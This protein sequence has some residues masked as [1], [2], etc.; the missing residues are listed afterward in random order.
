MSK[1]Y[2]RILKLNAII[3]IM[4]SEFIPVTGAELKRYRASTGTS[5]QEMADLLQVKSPS[6]LS[7]WENGQEI[8][9]P[10]QLLLRMLIHGE[11]PFKGDTIPPNIRDAMWEL[12]MSLETWEEINRRRIAGGYATVTDWIAS[13]V[14]E[15]LHEQL[16]NN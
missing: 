12:E 13:L 2:L 1:Q 15:E 11:V 5:L 3:E 9:G 4:P 10:A 8:P 14:R 6:T 7:A 16:L